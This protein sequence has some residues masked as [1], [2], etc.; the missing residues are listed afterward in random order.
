MRKR[1]PD[2]KTLWVRLPAELHEAIRDLGQRRF[3]PRS[4]N[5]EALVAL[6]D[7]VRRENEKEKAD[8]P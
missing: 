6:H 7:W 5:E 1:Q 3:P 8:A 4:M 2:W